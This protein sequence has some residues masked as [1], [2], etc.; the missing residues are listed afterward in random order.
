LLWPVDAGEKPNDRVAP[1]RVARLNL[2]PAGLSIPRDAEGMEAI[3]LV[4]SRRPLPPFAEWRKQV[5]GLRWRH[6]PPSR[7]AMHADGERVE[8][9]LP[10][11]GVVA[12]PPGPLTSYLDST[13]KALRYGGGMDA[14]RL[15]AFPVGD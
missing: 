7:Q 13:A 8:A 9:L 2:A 3:A 12:P 15:L 11:E 14:V 5:R 6:M 1:A 10:G 4:A